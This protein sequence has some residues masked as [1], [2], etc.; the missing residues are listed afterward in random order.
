MNESIAL[1]TG[2]H[3]VIRLFDAILRNQ[4]ERENEYFVHSILTRM[5]IQYGR[6]HSQLL[7]KEVDNLGKE[8]I[9]KL[10]VNA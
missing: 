9:D 6:E 1:S 7:S 5:V 3:N 4:K 2:K 8:N 10:I